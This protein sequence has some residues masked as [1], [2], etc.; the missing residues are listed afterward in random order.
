MVDLWGWGGDDC[1][2]E[3]RSEMFMNDSKE[4]GGGVMSKDIADSQTEHYKMWKPQTFH[5][6]LHGST[7]SSALHVLL[8]VFLCLLGGLN[9]EALHKCLNRVEIYMGCPPLCITVSV[10]FCPLLSHCVYL[11]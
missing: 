6:L 11:R 3:E 8:C 7:P 2:F 10:A 1:L 9:K 5:Y 4:G